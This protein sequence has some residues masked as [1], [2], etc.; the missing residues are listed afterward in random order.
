VAEQMNSGLHEPGSKKTRWRAI[1]RSVRGVSHSR[2]GLPNQDAISCIPTGGPVPISILAIADGHGS[3]RCFR[4]GLGAALAVQA[5]I[6]E[7]EGSLIMS[8][9]PGNP[10][11]MK[12]GAEQSLPAAIV[13]HWRGSVTNHFSHNPFSAEELEAVETARGAAERESVETNALLSYGATLLT[14]LA[15]ES[16]ILYLQLG[17]GD[18]LA[19]FEE[20]RVERPLPHDKRLIANETTSLCLPNA[21][22]EFR[23]ELDALPENKPALIM[24]S[25][26]GYANSF[27]DD[28][29]FRKV[30]SDFLRLIRDQGL[31]AVDENLEAWLNET[32]KSGS[33]DDISVGLAYRVEENTSA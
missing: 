6:A 13:H 14:V 8:A 4:S 10:L 31:G 33:G 30:G 20:G 2:T 32:S 9:D 11:V 3:P 24:L 18:I 16:F 19:I 21:E 23:F 12:E 15:T 27:V 26:D 28:D 17:D 29:A 22:R 7:C 1:A 25:T 5:A